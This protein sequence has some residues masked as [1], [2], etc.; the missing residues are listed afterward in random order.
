VKDDVR[1][2]ARRYA[3]LPEPFP[4]FR[5]GALSGARI[6]FETWGELDPD[7]GNALLLFTGLS[8]P[9]H[10]A[11]SAADP[12]DGWWEEMIGP[13]RPIDTERFFV[14]CVNS[15]GSCFGSTGPATPD[16]ASGR[17]YRLTFPELT[18]EDIARSGYEAA[19]ALGIETLHAVIGP[20]L[21]GMVVLAFAALLPGRARHLISISGTAAAAPFALALRSL[22]REAITRDPAWRAGEYRVDE[23][24]RTGMRLARKLGTITYRSAAEWAQRFGRDPVDPHY[25]TADPFGPTFAVEGYLEAQAERFTRTFD[26]NCYLYL[27][28]AMDRFDLGAHGDIA[29]LLGRAR[30]ESALI[31]GVETDLL[32]AIGEQRALA[33]AFDAAGIRTRFL[34]L[35]SIEGHDAFLVDLPRFG[36]AIGGFLAET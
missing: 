14:I 31:I 33:R 2:D 36:A 22:Q 34:A 27:S 3:A 10:A 16:P 1:A 32:F 7:R 4:M 25:R 17:P 19:R 5:G 8:P 12:T 28:R 24:P 6:A 26:A 18:V 30:L 20:S 9:A 11:S 15:L 21:G 23:P 29:E 35:P 13:G